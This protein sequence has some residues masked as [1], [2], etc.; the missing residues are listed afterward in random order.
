MLGGATYGNPNYTNGREAEIILNE[1]TG[2]NLSNL[3]GYTEIFGSSAEF[4]FIQS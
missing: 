3:L 1:V 2:S 4:N